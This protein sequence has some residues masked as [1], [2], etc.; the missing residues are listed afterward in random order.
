[1]KTFI[2]IGGACPR[3]KVDAQTLHNYFISNGLKPVNSINKADIVAVYSCGGFD[4][5]E[6][7]TIKTVEKV[8]KQKKKGAKVF[9]T[10]CLVKINYKALENMDVM[11]IEY[12]RLY[13]LDKIIDAKIKFSVIPDA[14][15][16]HDIPDLEGETT[17]DRL[18]KHFSVSASF[19][20]NGIK[21]ILK[22]PTRKNKSDYLFGKGVYN[23]MIARGCLGNCTYCSIKVAHGKLKSKPLKQVIRDIKYGITQG[24]DKFVLIGEDIGC[25]GQDIKTDI[26]ELLKEVFLIEQNFKVILNDL[27]P[28]WLIKYYDEIEKI[29]YENK[30]RIIDLRIPIQSGSNS[31]LKQMNR[32]YKVE[33][34]IRVLNS[35]TKKIHGLKIKT[36]IIVGF[37]GETEDDFEDTIKLLK[38]IKFEKVGIYNYEDRFVAK[39]SKFNNKVPKH[40]IQKRRNKIKRVIY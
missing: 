9:V 14:G 10:G 40:V 33:D 11:Q 4:H 36:H 12:E 37:P 2:V 18:K 6:K 17:K 1:M 26:V 32:N 24:Y 23:I 29:L 3:R 20:K 7:N 13:E 30:D 8:L 35:L 21:Y 15:E 31:I 16:I 27:N 19:L 25:Y 38:K 28:F 34:V 39:S 5:S 22:Y